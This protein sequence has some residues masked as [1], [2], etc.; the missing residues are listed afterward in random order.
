M[1]SFGGSMSLEAG[2]EVLKICHFSFALATSCLRFKMWDLS[3]L[4][5][6]PCLLPSC[7]G[8][9]R[10]LELW[11]Q[12]NPSFSTWPG[13]R[14]FVTATETKLANVLTPHWLELATQPRS[15]HKGAEMC[16]HSLFH[17]RKGNTRLLSKQHRCWQQGICHKAFVSQKASCQLVC[18]TLGV[19]VR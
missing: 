14:C 11:A 17:L 4:L 13:S 15:N 18:R 10:F 2:L 1:W 12:M 16:T 9:F 19:C 5:Q 7:N 6:P 8:T 3:L